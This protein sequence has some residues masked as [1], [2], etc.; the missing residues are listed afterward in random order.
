MD[1]NKMSLTSDVV[2]PVFPFVGFSIH[3][4]KESASLELSMESLLFAILRLGTFL[5]FVG[6]AWV[7]YYW[8]GPY[9]VL[10]WNETM[11]SWA[12]SLGYQWEDIVGTGANDGLFQSALS[13]IYWGYLACALVAL[14][15]RKERTWSLLVLLLGSCM[16]GIL[17]YAKY[18]NSK[19]QLPMFVE[20]GGQILMPAILASA[21]YFGYR[22]KITLCLALF[23]F[24]CTFAGHG[25]YALDIWPTPS[26]FYGMISVILGFGYDTAKLFLR[27]AGALDMLVCLGVFIPKMRFGCALYA[28]CW[29]LLTALARPV[30]GMSFTL[31]YWGADQYLHEAVL[32]APHFMIPLF[33]VLLWIKPAKKTL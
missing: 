29:G 28:A 24:V 22:H 20:H 19:G 12:Q 3:H 30:A 4:K 17:M 16:L 15:A 7:H 6:W 13:Q 2:K 21:L 14:L 11:Y 9:A 18:L 8:E 33:L 1:P 5:C 32:R 27:T 26:M 10:I 23:A 25:C 31:N